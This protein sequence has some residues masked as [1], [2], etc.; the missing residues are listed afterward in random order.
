MKPAVF[1]PIYKAIIRPSLEYGSAIW[2]PM[3]I[4]DKRE[5]EMVQRRATKL[6]RSITRLSYSERL[7]FLKLDSL[8]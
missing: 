2:N 5:I 1:L 3:L 7:K 4:Q 8:C 6:V